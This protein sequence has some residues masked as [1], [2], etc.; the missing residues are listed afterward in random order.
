MVLKTGAQVM[1]GLPGDNDARAVRTAEELAVLKPDLA[2]IYPLLVLHGSRLAQWYKT[3]QY[4]PLSLDQAVNQ[5][6]KWSQ[7]LKPQGSP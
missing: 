6:K 3:G 7:S 4:A 1:V 5:T 2:R